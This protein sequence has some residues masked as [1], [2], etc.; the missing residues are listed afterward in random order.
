MSR[1]EVRAVEELR[2]AV[3]VEGSIRVPGDK[4]IAHRALILGALAAGTSVTRGVPL[5][6]DVQATATCVA[7][8]GVGRLKGW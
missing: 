3:R 1:A 2:P 7:A 4:S 6:E 5:G 8:L